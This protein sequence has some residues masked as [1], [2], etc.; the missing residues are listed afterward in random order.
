[1]HCWHITIASVERATMV[2]DPARL[3][4]AVRAL[5]RVGGQQTLLFNL[6]DSHYHNIMVGSRKAAG[7]LAQAT[8]LSLRA[9]SR[10]PLEPARINE[11]GR[12]R[13]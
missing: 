10:A 7:R 5:A 6:V 8:S 3:R 13:P 4:Q 11:S 12:K 9:Y 2:T 1:M